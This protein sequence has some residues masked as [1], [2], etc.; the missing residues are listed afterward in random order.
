MKERKYK[1][2]VLFVLLIVLLGVVFTLPVRAANHVSKIELDVVLQADGSALITQVMTADTKEGTEFYLVCHDSGYLSI[3]DFSVSDEKETYTYT[4]NWDED[5]SFEEKTGTCGIVKTDAGVELCW[6]ISEYGKKCYTVRYVVHDLV[7]SYTDADGFH[8]RFVDEMSFFPTDV[9]LIIRNQEGI[10]FCDETCDIWAFG[11]KGQIQF[12]DGT[13]R[14]WSDEPLQ[15]GQ[16]MTIMMTLEKGILS[17]LRME[18]ESFEKV[19]AIAFEDSDYDFDERSENIG[20]EEITGSDI[21]I[22]IL[23]LGFLVMLII[24]IGKAAVKLRHAKM[25]RK[26][27]TAEY[28]RD[29][30]NQGNLN[31]TY[32]LGRS[33]E[34]CREDSLFGAYLLRLVCDGSLEPEEEDSKKAKLRLIRPPRSENLYDDVFYT[35][36]EAAA[37]EDGVLGSEEFEHYCRKNSKPIRQ[38]FGSCVRDARQTLTQNSYIKGAVCHGVRDL[39]KDG[40]RQLDEI[41]GLKRFLLDFSLIHEREVKETIIWQDYMVYALLLGIADQVLPQIRALYPESLPQ[42]QNFERCMRYAGSYNVISYQ[43]YQK[44][45]H[46]QIIRSSGSGGHAS[47]RGGQGFS[48]GGGGGT[49]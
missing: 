27:K 14:A 45:H 23:F 44:G 35:I 42:L 9:T 20:D 40:K 8:Y 47:F 11:Y 13:V 7:G 36:I 46:D 33:C 43:A 6:G 2:A 19:K 25:N 21:L 22:T 26:M 30:P 48:G 31:V 18:E 12:E 34:L 39:T 41:L 16:N 37:G 15:S 1:K 3:T 38:F 5:A 10:V 29:V 4:E 32:E 24:G 17:P 49:R 28:F